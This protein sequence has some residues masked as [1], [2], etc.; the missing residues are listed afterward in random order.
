M[1]TPEAS[2]RQ[3]AWLKLPEAGLPVGRDWLR[4]PSAP[5]QGPSRGGP[6]AVSTPSSDQGP[7]HWAAVAWPWVGAAAQLILLTS[8]TP[9]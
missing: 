7:L 5:L 4:I 9:S 1:H 2:G 6:G 3:W 8:N